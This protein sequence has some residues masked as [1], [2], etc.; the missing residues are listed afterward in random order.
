MNGLIAFSDL[1]PGALPCRAPGCPGNTDIYVMEANGSNAH[2]ITSGFDADGAPVW[3]PDGTKLLF[4]RGDGGGEGLEL[5]VMDADGSNQRQLTFCGLTHCVHGGWWGPGGNQISYV[6]QDSLHVMAASGSGDRVTHF[7]PRGCAIPVRSPDGRHTASVDATPGG[8]SRLFVAMADGSESKLLHECDSSKCRNGGD[9][10]THATW[11]PDGKRIAFYQEGNIWEV[12]ADGKDLGRV[13]N[14]TFDR[15]PGC[16][17]ANP[18]W[19]PDGTKILFWRQRGIYVMNADGSGVTRL[20]GSG[21][22]GS[23]RSV[24]E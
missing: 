22:L 18:I 6:T 1:A 10:I 7:C 5:F 8:V 11:S 13:T 3:S 4:L 12:G 24:G 19:S 14:C 21:F 17:F 23:W 16:L 15:R 9:G 20:R 2:H